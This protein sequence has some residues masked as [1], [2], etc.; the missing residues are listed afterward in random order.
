M[1]KQEPNSHTESTEETDK[2]KLK[3]EARSKNYMKYSGWGYTL[4]GLMLVAIL[5]GQKAD[6]YFEFENPVVTL[7]LLGIVIFTQFYKLIRDLA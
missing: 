4:F 2:S 3:I 6:S 7:T 5:V 1:S